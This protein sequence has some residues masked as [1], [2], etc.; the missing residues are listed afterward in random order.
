MVI[1]V[2]FLLLTLCLLGSCENRTACSYWDV[3]QKFNLTDPLSPNV[4]PVKDWNSKTIV[5]IDFDLYSIVSLDTSL[6]TLTT[7]LWLKMTWQ[8]EFISWNPDDFCG[9]D[10][11]YIS[12][13]S[14]WKP[15]LFIYEM[16]DN[17]NESIKTLYY[18]ITSNGN[19]SYG[20]PL[21]IETSCNMSMF[22][23]PFDTQTCILTF[24]PYV[25]RDKE[26]T[27]LSKSNDSVMN[28][29]TKAV[30]K[31]KGE[32]NFDHIAVENKLLL[33]YGENYSQVS[34]QITITRVPIVYVINLII[35]S[36]FLVLLDVASMFMPADTTE[37]LGFKITI[38]LGFSVVLLILNDM[39]PNS[40]EIPA[41]G[42]FCCVCMGIMVFSII[43]S[44]VTLFM[45]SRSETQ[46]EVPRWVKIWIMKYLARILYVKQKSMNKDVA[47]VMM[48]D[49]NVEDGR[50]TEENVVLRERSK[51]VSK[52]ATVS[53]EVKLLKKLLM[54]VLKIHQQLALHK[55]HDDTK[56]EWLFAA[57]VVDRL[58][59]I[60]YL[61]IIIVIF[62]VV[63]VVWAS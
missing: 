51:C 13:D 21:R 12:G 61:I 57:I 54:E 50:K 48:V 33:F 30:F 31:S 37:K 5:Y 2:G 22:K 58:I 25:H 39:I 52:A 56:A 27:M 19:V 45:Q 60:I 1:R 36:C 9:I 11:V 24:G 53:L 6:Q 15:D 44:L 7:L 43:A 3:I 16:T 10:R 63:I 49:Q 23:F 40:D 28:K 32:W 55:S 4:R 26:I 62:T 35:P 59:L 34:Y 20:A 17:S 46:R 38:V 18:T 41:L 47:T 29:K 8:N 14:L 42:I